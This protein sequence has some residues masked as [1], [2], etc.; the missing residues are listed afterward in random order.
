MTAS[1][2][3]YVRPE[4]FSMALRI[5]IGMAVV[6]V[7]MV[8]YVTQPLAGWAALTAGAAALAAA[9]QWKKAR[10]RS[11]LPGLVKARPTVPSHEH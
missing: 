8:A 1:V 2:L 7:L 5:S 10:Q 6:A 3:R 11:P 4:D 9:N